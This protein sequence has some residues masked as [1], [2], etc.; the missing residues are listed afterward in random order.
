[1]GSTPIGTATTMKNYFIIIYDPI[2]AHQTHVGP[3]KTYN[4]AKSGVSKLKKN[5]DLIPMSIENKED[6]KQ[7]EFI[8]ELIYKV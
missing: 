4:Q 2:R 7:L 1:M 6:L 8:I 3:Y 5:P